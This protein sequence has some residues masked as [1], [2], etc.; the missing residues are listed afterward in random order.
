VRRA[1]AEALRCPA[2][3]AGLELENRSLDHSRVEEGAL[4]C[5]CGRAFPV[6][7][8]IPRLLPDG[9]AA[10]LAADHP[11]FFARH[12]DLRTAGTGRSSASLRTLRAFGDEW[13]RF[14]ELLAVH[15]RIFHW[16]FEGPAKPSWKGLRV[17]D[18][19]CGMGRWLHF[20]RRMGAEVVGM[21]LSGAID[22]AAAREGARA[23]FAQADLRW[24]P[25]PRDSFDV[26]YSLGVIHHLEDPLAGV[27]S[28]ATLVRPGGELR[29]YV[30]RS[31]ETEGVVKRVL[32]YLVTVLR[33]V[34][35]RLPYSA[36]HAVAW[37]IAVVATCAFLVP[38]R[39]LRRWPSGERLTSAAAPRALRRRSLPNARG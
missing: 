38:R 31:F 16:Y 32:L 19:G 2:C 23:D 26:V 28:L 5:L 15:E 34:T 9:L 29:L 22:V 13:Q 39:V 25:F 30:Y 14:P 18:A 17:L 11:D 12:A 10:T 27:R 7:A 3:L 36:V 4:R 20:A 35:T 21:D 33:Q 24:P 6:I 8:G 37:S 1:F